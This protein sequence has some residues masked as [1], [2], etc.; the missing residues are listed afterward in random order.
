MDDQMKVLFAD[1]Y[2][3]NAVIKD[4]V[5]ANTKDIDCIINDG[6]W[7]LISMHAEA[8]ADQANRVLECAQKMIEH[9]NAFLENGPYPDQQAGALPLES[10]AGE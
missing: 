2:Q 9:V 3:M 1:L 5:K 7:D 6:D 4:E 10:M 8:I